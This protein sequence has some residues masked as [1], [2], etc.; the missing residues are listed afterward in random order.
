MNNRTST[1]DHNIRV[2][3]I[4]IGGIGM[5]GIAEILLKMGYQVS[6]SDIASSSVTERLEELGAKVFIG[7]EYENATG[8][9]VVVYS[10]AI[11]DSN[12]EIVWA[13]ENKVPLMKRAEMIAELMRLKEG[14]AVA[15]THGKTTTTS[16]L[17]TIMQ[18]NQYNPT[19][20]IGGIVANLKGHASVGDGKFL[21]VE[22]DESDGSF[23]LLNPVYSLITNID[24]DHLDFYGS[25]ENIIQAFS[26]FS[27][28]IP[29]YGFCSINADDIHT[30]IILDS[31]RKPYITYGMDNE[32][33]PIEYRGEVLEI[34]L[35]KSRFKLFYN[36]EYVRDYVVHLPGKHNIYNALG[37]ISLAHKMGIGFDDIAAALEKFR[38]VKR[39]FQKLYDGKT[40]KLYDDYGHHPTEIQATISAA[41]EAL[42]NKDLT[43]IFE[44]HR[45]SRTKDCWEQFFHCFNGADQVFI[46]PIYPASESPIPGISSDNLC[47]DINKVHPHLVRHLDDTKQ[48][49]RL[50]TQMKDDKVTVLTLGAGSI[51]RN[52]R[53]WVELNNG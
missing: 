44:P 16:M 34:N 46:L 24:D 26:D 50:L 43:V 19:Y 37:A 42:G 32:S 48:M 14:I 36:G 1:I 41:K 9:S 52:I 28:K 22:A 33:M 18:E 47:R 45:F 6:G 3:F 15:G 30:D 35:D 10:S 5:S 27:N 31:M 2:H 40:F 17:T 51:G 39:R 29:F 49:F 38:G 23:L 4:G 21:T 53:E 8:A 12:P 25:K 20:I 11:N 7:H 13:R